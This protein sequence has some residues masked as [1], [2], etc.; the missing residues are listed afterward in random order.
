LGETIILKVLKRGYKGD[1]VKLWQ[2]FLHIEPD[3][4]FGR[5]TE[6]NTKE[7]QTKNG[8]K[9]DGIAGS[10]TIAKAVLLG[11]VIPEKK[12]IKIT[13]EQLKYIMKGCRQSS[14][15]KYLEPVNKA[16]N[17]YEIDTYLRICHFLAQVGH[18]SGSLR[19]SHEL[20]SGRMY[21]GRKDLGNIC[22]GDG[23]RFKGQGLIQI[24]GRLN[25]TSFGKFIG[26]DFAKENPARIGDEPE[27]SAEAAGWFW[28]T[29]KLNKWADMDDIK[30][31]S[32]RVNGGYNGLQERI[33]YL[34]R[35]K[36]SLKS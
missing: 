33:L 4:I 28:M 7:F 24:T 10:K 21:E 1:N 20:A 23:M 27:L 15:L 11:F 36:E 16:M 2:E 31:V 8:L 30:G 29:R 17:K 35:A 14:I 13:E 22:P 19:Y 9:A 3:G 32:L 12:S 5:I 34:K 26:I 18:E 25:I 6:E